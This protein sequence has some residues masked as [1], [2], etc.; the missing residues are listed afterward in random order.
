[1]SDKLNHSDL[2]ALFAKEADISGAKA[3]NFTKAMFELIIEGLEQDGTVKINGL[4]TFKITDVADRSSVNVNTGEKIEI[5]GHKKISFT[6][7]D[8][9]KESVNQPF[10][11]FE[12]VE[13]DENYKDD[14]EE[15]DDSASEAVEEVAAP[16][17]VADLKIAEAPITVETVE[18]APVEEVKIPEVIEEEMPADDSDSVAVEP[19]AV[20]ILPEEYAPA[21]VE[22]EEPVE[23]ADVVVEDKQED[24]ESETSETEEPEI[25]GDDAVEIIVEECD[26]AVVAPTDAVLPEETVEVKVNE[27][28]QEPV[29]VQARSAE[30]V[31]VHVPKKNGHED[32]ETVPAKKK[33]S[34]LRFNISFII[35][36][37]AG[38]LVVS[39]LGRNHAEDVASAESVADDNANPVVVVKTKS[40]P[41][42][43]NVESEEN[44][45]ADETNCFPCDTVIVIENDVFDPVKTPAVDLSA[46]EEPEAE[47]KYT[48]VLLEAVNKLDLK[49]L[50]VADTTLYVAEGELARHTVAADET[51]TRIARQYYGDKRLWPYI[52]KYNG[53]CDPNGLCRGMELVIP[54]L[55]PKK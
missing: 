13:V 40:E 33:N 7:A 55:V 3:E 17:E 15:S 50:T 36:V 26:D 22:V 53:M 31:M 51:L 23:I 25:V 38:V 18:E 27:T 19:V 52:V 4:G 29:A 8:A 6:P 49:N 39:M 42:V 30:P 10:A 48:F 20:E 32:K 21:V 46:V 16:V 35:G 41:V 5:K 54:R 1:M 24:A 11:M 45:V 43:S 44:I 28:V 47:E 34:K 37:L 12:P 2:S 9:I 14:A